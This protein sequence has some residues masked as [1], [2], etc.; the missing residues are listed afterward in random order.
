MTFWQLVEKNRKNR[1]FKCIRKREMHICEQCLCVCR[2]YAIACQLSPVE[3]SSGVEHLETDT[4]KLHCLQTQTGLHENSASAYQSSNGA[5]DL[6]RHGGCS[7]NDKLD[8]RRS[9]KLTVPPSSDAWPLKFITEIVSLE[10][11]LYNAFCLW[12]RTD[13][14]SNFCVVGIIGKI[15]VRYLVNCPPYYRLQHLLLQASNLLYARIQAE[16]VKSYCWRSCMKSIPILLWRIRFTVWTCRS[17]TS[18]CD[19]A[20]NLLWHRQDLVQRGH[21]TIRK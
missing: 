10:S 19:V 12:I 4:F 13:F 6:T 18:D 3:R 9:T 17:G 5:I 15:V 20:E 11:V 8:R 16:A 2:L 14:Y 21:R 7:E 1:F